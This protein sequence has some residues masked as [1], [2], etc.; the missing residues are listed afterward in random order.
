MSNIVKEQIDG[1]YE[2]NRNSMER[3]KCYVCIEEF[4]GYVWK[5]GLGRRKREAD[6][7]SCVC[8]RAGGRGR[9]YSFL[10]DPIVKM[11]EEGVMWGWRSHVRRLRARVKG[12]AGLHEASC[13]YQP[14]SQLSKRPGGLS[15]HN[16]CH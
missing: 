5:R 7:C 14:S 15:H 4:F 9:I 16:I 10:K 11:K 1:N 12:A 8:E 13:F 6:L 3:G 2:R